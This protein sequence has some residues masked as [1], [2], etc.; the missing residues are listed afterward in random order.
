MCEDD[1]PTR[2]A[3]LRMIVALACQLDVTPSELAELRS[4]AED[5]E[6]YYPKCYIDD[7]FLEMAWLAPALRNFWNF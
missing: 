2:V 7:E 1:G 4:H 6:Q 3:L 5:N